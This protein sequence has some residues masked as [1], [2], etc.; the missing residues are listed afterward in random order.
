MTNDEIEN[1]RKKMEKLPLWPERGY[2]KTEWRLATEFLQEKSLP[3]EDKK[4]VSE[5]LN[6]IKELNAQPCTKKT[7]AKM[8]DKVIDILKII[9]PEK[10]Y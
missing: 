1:L 6:D 3:L 4:K 9:F 8:E 7:I 5:L 10:T 2:L